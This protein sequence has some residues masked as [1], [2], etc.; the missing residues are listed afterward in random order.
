MDKEYSPIGGIAEFG[1]LTA[2]LALGDK[3]TAIASQRVRSACFRT[4][5]KKTH[6]QKQNKTPTADMAGR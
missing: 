3:C 4:L 6:K 5:C 1:K 2:Q